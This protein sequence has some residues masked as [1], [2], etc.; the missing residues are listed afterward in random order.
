MK[1]LSLYLGAVVSA[2]LVSSAIAITPLDATNVLFIKQEEK[3]ARDVYLALYD[4]WGQNIFRNI[5][6]QS[7]QQHMDSVD[8]LIRTYS[9]VDTTPAERGK[10]TIPELQALHDQL[11]AKGNRSLIDALLVGI[12]IE[13]VD[14][15]DLQTAMDS[16]RDSV[17]LTVFN[18]LQNGSRNHL[19]AFN[20]VLA[21]LYT[22][23][24]APT[25]SLLAT[26]D[27]EIEIAW[28]DPANN[29]NAFWVERRLV[30]SLVWERIGQVSANTTSFT[31]ATPPIEVAH[32][33]VLAT[34]VYE[35]GPASSEAIGLRAF[36][37][38]QEWRDAVF[39][40]QERET[41]GLPGIDA[42]NDG[43]VNFAEYAFGLNPRVAAWESAFVTREYTRLSTSA[44][45]RTG[46]G[47][48]QFH[49]LTSTDLLT[50]RKAS[51]AEESVVAS[52]PGVRRTKVSVDLGTN[53]ILF[54][55]TV[56]E[57]P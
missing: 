52:G 33:R 56:V 55:R 1:K 25:L 51:D 38:Y 44:Y 46:T 22:R 6:T 50:W 36:A 48:L 20:N 3:L 40:E 17:I 26:N 4:K 8:V 34:N 43:L 30:G 14:I 41:L 57:A 11:M 21:P 12:L 35:I 2:V 5:G 28:N 10:F 31:D 45:R 13:E 42:D 53:Q 37:S 18:N 16:T 29:E 15:R 7:E 49:N 9:L 19:V 32:Y 23:L 27:G 54:L 24:A 39:L 47:D